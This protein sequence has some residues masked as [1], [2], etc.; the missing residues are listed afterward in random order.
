MKLLA[1]TSKGLIVFENQRAAWQ[2]N[3]IHFEGLT[4]SM[5]YIDD[6]TGTWWI[7]LSH[8]HWGEKLH[9]SNDEGKQWSE[10]GVPSY[11]GY[12]YRPDKPASLK[13]IW[14]MEHAGKDKP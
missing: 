4:V 11:T 6:R 13:K 12:H 3:A 14:V 9:F 5:V 2:T 8:R 1:G 10:A 7:G